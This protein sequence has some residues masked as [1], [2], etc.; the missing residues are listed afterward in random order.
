MS[1]NS[2]V[3]ADGGEIGRA[4]AMQAHACGLAPTMRAFNPVLLKPGSDRSS[5]V[6]VLGR[7]QGTVSALSYREHQ[8]ALDVVTETLADLRAARRRRL[9]GRRLPAD[10]PAGDRHR[11]HGARAGRGPA[12]RRGRRHHRRVPRAPVRHHGARA[13]DQAVAGFVINGAAATRPCSRR[14]RA[15]AGV[16]RTADVRRRYVGRRAITRRRGLAL[17]GRGRRARPAG[18]AARDAVAAGRGRPAAADLQRDRR[19]GAGLRAGGGGA[20]RHRAVAA[21][22]RGPRR[23]ARLEGDRPRTSPR[24]GAAGSP[25]R[26]RR[27]R[28]PDGPCWGSAAATRCWGGGSPTHS[29]RGRRRRS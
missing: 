11:E 2:V 14:A 26:W 8:D 24:C 9:R 13:A 10:Q 18:A 1:N 23:A 22:R 29:R 7:A 27:T 19:R 28:G 16:D 21:R 4:Q 20:L 17:R 12:R 5:Q 6:V 15:A 25:T 3:T